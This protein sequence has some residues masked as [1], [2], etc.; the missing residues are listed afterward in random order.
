MLSSRLKVSETSL[1]PGEREEDKTIDKIKVNI[2]YNKKEDVELQ[3]QK[4]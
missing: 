3:E 2:S 1:L 4:Q